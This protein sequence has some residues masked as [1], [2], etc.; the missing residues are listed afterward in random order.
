[1]I[2]NKGFSLIEL[3]IVFAI[4]ALLVMIGFNVSKL[5]SSDDVTWSYVGGMQQTTCIGG[6]QF[7]VNQNGYTTQILGADG[8]PLACN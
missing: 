8:K 3:L 4:V 2:R 1:M 7:T 5:S 6:F